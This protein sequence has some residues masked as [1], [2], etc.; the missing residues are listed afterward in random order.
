MQT[1]K[2]TCNEQILAAECPGRLVIADTKQ[3]VFAQFALDSEW[4]G[5]SVTAV[6]SNDFGPGSVSVPLMGREVA[7]PP[8]VLVEG[9][10]RAS[11]VGLRDGGNYRLTTAYMNKPVIVHRAGDLIG[12]R[13]EDTTPELWE[14]ALAL[15][16]PLAELQTVDK[17]SLVAAINEVY[18]TGG[19]SSGGGNVYS[20]EITTIKVLERAEYDA[21]PKP[22]PAATAYLI[23]G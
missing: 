10:L 12:L 23:R 9:R 21:L 8:E 15:I 13:P 18:R 1:L 6:F 7:V 2:F 19:P 20:A 4:D 22:R 14:Q 5:L 16:G 3:H 11:L 17:S